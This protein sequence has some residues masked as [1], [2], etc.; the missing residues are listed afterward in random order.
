MNATFKGMENKGRKL[1]IQNHKKSKE[2]MFLAKQVS[3][4][5]EL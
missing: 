3:I 1:T 4:S 2:N 5:N